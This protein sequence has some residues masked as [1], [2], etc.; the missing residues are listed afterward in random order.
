MVDVTATAGRTR[1]GV[2]LA[3]SR[4]DGLAAFV[5]TTLAYL[6]GYLLA[7]QDLTIAATGHDVVVVSD[8]LARAFEQTTG[9]FSYEAVALVEA[10]VVTVLVSPLNLLIGGAIATLVGLNAAVS[11]LLW[12]QPKACGIDG[13]AGLLAGLPALLSGAACCGPLVLIV[14]GVQASGVLLTAFDALIPVAVLLLVGGLVLA[15]RRL[16]P[17]ERTTEA[18]GV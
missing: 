18:Q 6:L 1:R 14:L 7:V 4:R 3:L 11:V 8:P 9:P 5:V 15:T 10:G 17:A 16:L 12:R 2:A 13:S